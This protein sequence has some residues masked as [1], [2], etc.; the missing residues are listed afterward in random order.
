M[1]W[2]PG[3]FIRLPL[4]E[5]GSASVGRV[6][7][8]YLSRLTIQSASVLRRV[9]L[10]NAIRVNSGGHGE[11]L[12]EISLSSLESAI[13]WTVDARS[14]RRITYTG[15]HYAQLRHFIERQSLRLRALGTSSVCT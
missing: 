13:D 6:E 5:E 8:G 4:C 11:Y 1:G 15:P 2:G 9:A 14:V 10:R 3:E 12:Q 7:L